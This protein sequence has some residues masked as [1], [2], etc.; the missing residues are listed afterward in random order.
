MT[1]R[2]G[3][4]P[5]WLFEVDV[6]SEPPATELE[7]ALEQVL[8]TAWHELLRQHMPFLYAED[9]RV[10]LVDA[11]RSLEHLFYENADHNLAA[12]YEA[13]FR[14]KEDKAELSS[15]VWHAGMLQCHLM[16]QAFFVLQLN[17]YANAP[18][19]R[20][21]MNLFR[22]WG[23]SWT[24]NAIFDEGRTLSSQQFVR[25]YDNYVR[26]YGKTIDEMPVRHPWDPRLSP[27]RPPRPLDEVERERNDEFE[28]LGLSIPSVAFEIPGVFLDSGIVET[29]DAL[30]TQS[31]MPSGPGGLSSKEGEP[32]QQEAPKPDGQGHSPNA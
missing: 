14:G 18:S 30:S 31:E 19:N 5:K 23:A 8:D 6:P 17:R 13:T 7:E 21:W 28:F 9:A 11:L 26:Y 22:R 16:E 20:G 2:S 10:R 27:D 32:V 1:P 24:F 15:M 3:V 25:F 29:T 4:K 12:Y